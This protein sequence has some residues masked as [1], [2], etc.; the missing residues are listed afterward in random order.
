MK[1]IGDGSLSHF[2]DALAACRA[3]AAIQRGM[4]Q[5]NSRQDVLHRRCCSRA[6]AC[7]PAIASLEKNDVFGDVVNTGLALRV[8]RESRR[9]LSSPRTPYNAHQRQDRVLR[10]LRPRSDA[11]GQEPAPSRRTS[12]SGIRRRSSATC[13][14]PVIAQPSPPIPGS[15]RSRYRIGMPLARLARRRRLHHRRRQVRRRAASHP[16]ASTTRVPTR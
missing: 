5:I 9:D 11:E 7:T 16:L 2:E 4:E 10:A 15:G 13:A 3:A 6:S 14:R 1:T 8:V 12:S